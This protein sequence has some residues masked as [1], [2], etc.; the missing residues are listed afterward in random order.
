MDKLIIE[1]GIGIGNIKLGMTKEEV[2]R[3]LNN[4]IDKYEK[5]QHIDENGN[6]I[7]YDNF[8]NS[9]FKI[10]YGKNNTVIFIEIVAELKSFFDC[11]CYD[12]NVFRTKAE[13][14]VRQL[15][16]MVNCEPGMEDDTECFLEDIGLSL[17]RSHALTE[18]DMEED[19][20]KEMCKENQEDERRF[21]Y[22]QTAAVYPNDGLYYQGLH[23]K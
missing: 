15:S 13:E 14:L 18:E 23:S 6:E 4:Y 1:P 5:A 3:H 21:M 11:I 22:F 8:F 19:W 12:I 16:K 9:A 2:D 7:F 10:E 17:W 20:F